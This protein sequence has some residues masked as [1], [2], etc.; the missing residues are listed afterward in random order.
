MGINIRSMVQNNFLKTII[1]ESICV[2]RACAMAINFN[3]A[4]I[5]IPMC[6][7][8][9]SWIRTKLLKYLHSNPRRLVNH[10]KGLHILC[11]FTMC[12][13]SVIHTLSHLVNSLRFHL[14]FTEAIEAINVAS[15][16]K[17]TTL[18][19]VLSKVPGWTGV[20]MLVL[21]AIIVLT[22]F[23]AVRRQNYEVFWYTHHLTIVFLILACFHGFGKITKF[24]TNLDKNPRE[25]HSLVRKM[26]KENSTICLEAPSFESNVP[27]TWKWIVGP[28]CLY[29]IDRIIRLFRA[30]KD[31]QVANVILHE[32]KMIELHMLKKGFKS[33]PGQYILLQCPD[34]SDLEW[35]AFT[36]TKCPTNDGG[37]ET[38]SV[39]MKVAGDWTK[40]LKAKFFKCINTKGI[41]MQRV[42]D[43]CIINIDKSI[44]YDNENEENDENVLPIIRVDG[45]YGSPNEDCFRYPVNISVA[46]GI[47]ITPFAAVL[48]KLRSLDPKLVDKNFKMKRMHLVWACR[49][50]QEFTWFLQLMFD[51]VK[52]LNSINMGDLLVCHLFVTRGANLT[53]EDPSMADYKIQ[54]LQKRLRYGRPDF[55][56]ILKKISLNHYKT[57]VGVFFCGPGPLGKVLYDACKSVNFRGNSFIFHKESFA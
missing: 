44:V 55:E 31:C 47:G 7:T 48:N 43:N 25:C 17:E 41:F 8:I 29:I 6:K 50:I 14:N 24:Q 45:P 53:T 42:G 11:A 54:W 36:L 35:H 39:N 3:L 15:S 16:K 49:D 28:L 34:I 37:D 18:W 33:K 22:S 46:A 4:L 26:W 32:D 23:Q 56:D 57:R 1:L 12:I 52:H 5:L 30:V 51:T 10:L 13:L 19:L 40:K 21:L 38:F 20:V 2:S 9:I 27:Q